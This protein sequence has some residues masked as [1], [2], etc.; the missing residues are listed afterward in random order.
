MDNQ[1]HYDA[2]TQVWQYILGKNFHWG[3]F[4]DS[5]QSLEEATEQ[6][7]IKMLSHIKINNQTHVLDIGCGIGIPAAYIAKKYSCRVTGISNSANG[8]EEATKLETIFPGQLKF[9]QRDALN[10]QFP[11]NNFDIAW[12][13]EMSHLIDDKE[14]L[15]KESARVLKGGGQIVLCDLMFQ[16]P[17]KA[18]EIFENQQNLVI[19]EHCFGKARLE[20]FDFYKNIFSKNGLTNIQFTDISNA[21]IPTL[22]AWKNNIRKNYNVIK[23]IISEKEIEEYIQSCDILEK[24]YRNQIWGYG[25]IS[26]IKH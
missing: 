3:Y 2:I 19:L 15:I 7:I 9:L 8:I 14:C 13:M 21:V 16:R 6:L 12:L 4:T 10:N 18:R 20:T 1:Q 17:Y 25:I 11:E 26:A 24:F 5:T 23:S 22:A